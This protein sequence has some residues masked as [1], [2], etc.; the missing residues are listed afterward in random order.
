MLRHLIVLA[1]CGISLYAQ[2]NPLLST[3]KLDPAR[4]VLDGP[5][6]AFVQ[7]GVFRARTANSPMPYDKNRPINLIL[8]SGTEKNIFQVT[9]SAD[10]RTMFIKQVDSGSEKFFNQH[11][12]ALVLDRQ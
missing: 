1:V 4:S 10:G 9:V 2:D 8:Y 6:P 12:L 7:D 11:H 3:W 5:L